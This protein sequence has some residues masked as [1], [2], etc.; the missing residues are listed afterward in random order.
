M[1]PEL[2][3]DRLYALCKSEAEAAVTTA[4][5]G[6]ASKLCHDTRV[7]VNFAEG[8]DRYLD[9]AKA[10]LHEAGY[11][12][13]ITAFAF[14][15]MRRLSLQQR[16][17]ADLRAASVGHLVD[18]KFVLPLYRTFFPGVRLAPGSE[19]AV[20]RTFGE[21]QHVLSG[22]P[23]A[24]QTSD[25]LRLFAAQ[26]AADGAANPRVAVH[27]INETS[28]C[29]RFSDADAVVVLTNFDAHRVALVSEGKLPDSG[30]LVLTPLQEY[31]QAK[32]EDTAAAAGNNDPGKKRPA[33][34][35]SAVQ[36]SPAKKTKV[37]S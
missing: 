37:N 12:S 21:C 32:D 4:A 34:N 24:Y 17:A 15:F 13:Y 11:D 29:V 33:S 19:D 3:L 26:T 9:P 30:A 1:F 8:H 23:A 36:V 18:C 22:F 7:I 14:A 2:R 35:N 27:W 6:T 28:A 16:G 25:V 10:I 31:M 20:A 5:A